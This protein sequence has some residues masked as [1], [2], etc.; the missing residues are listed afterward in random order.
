[1]KELEFA[2]KEADNKIYG[3]TQSFRAD[4]GRDIWN[5]QFSENGRYGNGNDRQVR[6]EEFQPNSERNNEYLRSGDKRKSDVRKTKLSRE[7]DQSDF[8]ADIKYSRESATIEDI[9]KENKKEVK[10][11]LNLY[12]VPQA[13]VKHTI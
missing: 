11:C 13:A 2:Y 6:S 3:N 9:K 5:L 4:K 12:W 7:I 8:E 10:K 1:M